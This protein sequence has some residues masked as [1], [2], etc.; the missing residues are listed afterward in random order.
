[1]FTLFKNEPNDNKDEWLQQH[2][3]AHY[4]KCHPDVHCTR[5]DIARQFVDPSVHGYI[6]NLSITYDIQGMPSVG[7]TCTDHC[8]L[9]PPYTHRTLSNA[10]KA[11]K[12]I[13]N[14]GIKINT[15][16]QAWGH[17]F[18]IRPVNLLQY[19][20]GCLVLLNNNTSLHFKCQLININSVE[21]SSFNHKKN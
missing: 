1:M 21:F 10:W 12:A 6:N 14:T 3:P 5:P 8:T 19:K 2:I 4:S 13:I 9:L 17:D 18:R 15:G 7:R 20:S 16:L 11:R